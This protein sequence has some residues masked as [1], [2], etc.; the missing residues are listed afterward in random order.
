MK[1]M[2]QVPKNKWVRIIRKKWFLPAVY[3]ILVALILS[4]VVWYQVVGND[5]LAGI[6]EQEDQVTEENQLINDDDALSVIRQEE[7]VKMP[8]ANTEQAEIVTK[9]YDYDADA[10]DQEKSLI[11]YNNRYYQS[12]GVNIALADGNSF[13][14]IASLSGT[15]TEVKED[16]LLGNVVTIE[17]D[18]EIKTYYASLQDVAVKSGEKV[19]QGQK[20]GTAGKNLFN[21]EAGIH[22]HFEISKDGKEVNPE[23]FFNQPVTKLQ[24]FEVNKEDAQ[25]RETN[26]E[27]ENESENNESNEEEKETMNDV[28]FSFTV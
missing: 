13:D 11:L 7:V 14:V 9:F 4:G 6:D 25:E 2:N 17:H 27:D 23:Q 22:V 3:L 26:K 5:W 16:P 10:A 19:E 12:T 21:E 18:D 8:L 24:E 28:S 20:I 15:V 1:E